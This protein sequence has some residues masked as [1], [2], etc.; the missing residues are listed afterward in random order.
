MAEL[1]SFRLRECIGVRRDGEWLTQGIPLAR[2]RLSDPLAVALLGPSGS[3][4]PVDAAVLTRWDD[5]SVK[6][7]KLSFA[8]TV[9]GLSTAE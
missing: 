2:G 6:W 4:V 5:G 1:T 9:D 8:A 7:L 3:S